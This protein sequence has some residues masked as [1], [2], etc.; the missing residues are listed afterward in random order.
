VGIEF[1]P[2]SEDQ[3]KH[4]AKKLE[5]LSKPEPEI[6]IAEELYSI[7][8]G[9]AYCVS[10]IQR[11]Y[12]LMLEQSLAN[13]EY[14]SKLIDEVSSTLSETN[15]IL[16]NLHPEFLKNYYSNEEPEANTNE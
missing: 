1:I 4:L 11:M 8:Q 7:N 3:D 2:E 5:N 6:N 13:K 16:N 12:S 9:I 14:N 15:S 10:K